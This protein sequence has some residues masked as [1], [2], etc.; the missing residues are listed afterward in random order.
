MRL[1]FILDFGNHGFK[2]CIIVNRC[3]FLSLPDCSTC[4]NVGLEKSISTIPMI[5]YQTSHNM[6]VGVNMSAVH[7][8]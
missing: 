5:I 8:S 4:Y 6:H 3:I 7:A 1:F 2:G